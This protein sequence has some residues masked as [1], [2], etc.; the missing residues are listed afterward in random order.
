MFQK[1]I[2]LQD[3]EEPAQDN[4]P[5]PPERVLR[6]EEIGREMVEE[7]LGSGTQA[8]V[9]RTCLA[10]HGPDNF[11]VSVEFTGYLSPP[12][13]VGVFGDHVAYLGTISD[14]GSVCVDIEPVPEDRD[15]V[16]YA[17][18]EVQQQ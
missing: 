15:S 5:F 1:E 8:G 6:L 3:T 11:S 16:T 12:Y 4:A 7:W 9:D 10:G 13:E 17:R 18:E 2:E 14:T